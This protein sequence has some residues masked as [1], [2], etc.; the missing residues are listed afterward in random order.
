ML[1][2]EQALG[3]GREHMGTYIF[4]LHMSSRQDSWIT[5]VNYDDMPRVPYSM[6]INYMVYVLS[7]F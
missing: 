3:H 6:R 7:V 5:A 4:G 1:S 2:N